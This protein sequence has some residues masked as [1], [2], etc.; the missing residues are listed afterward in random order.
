MDL[1]YDIFKKL[2]HQEI[3]YIRHQITSSAF[4]HEK[5]GKLFELVTQYEEQEES[6]YAKNIY[7]KAPD[8]TFR[9][10]KSRLKRMMENVVLNDKSLSGYG[11]EITNIQLQLKKKLLQAEI[12]L[13]RGAYSAGKNLLMQCIS[14]AHKYQLY[15]EYFQAEFLMF[16]LSSIRTPSKEFGQQAQLLK[17][18]NH[19]GSI[20]NEALIFHYS[21]TNLLLHKSL[22]EDQLAEVRLQIN[23]VAAIA[24]EIVHPLVLNAHYLCEIYYLQVK[25]DFQNALGFCEKYLELIQANPIY[26]TKQRLGGAYIQLSQVSLQL[27]ESEK[28]QLYSEE[29]IKFFLPDEMNYFVVQ[30]L[31]FRI[32]FYSGKYELAEECISRAFEHPQFQTSKIKAAQWQYFKVCLLVRKKDFRAANRSI[33]DTTPLLSD[34]YGWNLYVRLLEIMILFELDLFDP[35]DSRIQNMRQFLKRANKN[36]DLYRFMLLL[37]ILR[38]W[39]KVG[40]DFAKARKSVLP[41]LAEI[42]EYHVNNPFRKSGFELIRFEKWFAEKLNITIDF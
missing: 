4:E 13:G 19:N 37:K 38:E 25:G 27:G 17:E 21:I 39:Y 32:A 7:N 14:T 26:Y 16:R 42:K 35:L 11:T 30:E 24:S 34:K 15:Q 1:I 29:A 18:L 6:F 8:N 5:V 36:S 20:I 23:R 28:A 10:T 3:R 2:S 40:Y 41:I 9:V 22:S 31:M 33:L 12:L